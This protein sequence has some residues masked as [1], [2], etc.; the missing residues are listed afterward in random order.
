[1]VITVDKPV[2]SPPAPAPTPAPRLYTV[3][4]GGFSATSDAFAR[5]NSTDTL[6]FL[7]M[8]GAQT[9]LK[10]IAAALL[11]QS[12][13]AAH[14]IE[15]AEGMA[16]S[17]GYQ[18]CNIPPETIG[19]WTN[20]I[21]R[22]PVGHGHHCLVY[23]KFAEYANERDDFLLLARDQDSPPDLHYRFLDRRC[24]LPLH[25]SWA[26]WLWQR[27]LRNG[28]VQLLESSGITAYRCKPNFV[29]LQEALSEAVEDGLLRVNDEPLE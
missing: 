6:W 22:L 20:R 28:E 7:S 21:K 16:L 10:A 3:S 24:P 2:T 4:A 19:S 8:V 18:T 14:L 23:T 5:D 1:M 25:P 29:E 27:G 9:A 13:A 11:K 17:G 15:G 12:P 26:G